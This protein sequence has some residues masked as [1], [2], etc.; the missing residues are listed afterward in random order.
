MRPNAAMYRGELFGSNERLLQ[1]GNRVHS[2]QR[3]RE[4]GFDRLFDVD[5]D[6]FARLHKPMPAVETIDFCNFDKNQIQHI[7]PDVL[8][9]TDVVCR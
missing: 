6:V 3:G 7:H 9:A 1:R 2:K 4:W 8:V 5:R